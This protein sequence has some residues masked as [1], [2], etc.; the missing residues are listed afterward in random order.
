[1]RER[2]LREAA[3]LYGGDFWPEERQIDWVSSYRQALKRD[4]L[5]LMLDLSDLYMRQGATSNAI[6]TL[7]RLLANDPVMK[8][9]CSG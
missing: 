6:S 9:A 5:R 1:M 3:A 8:L 2:L 4:W 7:D